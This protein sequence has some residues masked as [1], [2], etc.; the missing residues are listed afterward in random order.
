MNSNEAENN[1]KNGGQP[2]GYQDIL[3]GYPSGKHNRKIL[4]DSFSFARILGARVTIA[5]VTDPFPDQLAFTGP[6]GV[7]PWVVKVIEQEKEQLIKEFRE[8]LMEFE[9]KT[10]ISPT[11]LT[12]E[13][14]PAEVLENLSQDYDITVIGSGR[15]KETPL[16]RLGSVARNVVRFAQS[17]VLVVREWPGEK[18]LGDVKR[19]LVPVDGSEVSGFAVAHASHI[20]QR[21]GA[22]ITLLHVWD[23]KDE[24]VIQRLHT[25]IVRAREVKDILGQKLLDRSEKSLAAGQQAERQIMEGDP[26]EIISGLSGS[27]DLVVMG[28]WGRTGLK[29]FLLGGVA[30]SVANHAHCAVLLIRG[31]SNE[32]PSS[33]T[34]TADHQDRARSFPST[35]PVPELQ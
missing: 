24:K 2:D 31:L 26:A 10:G 12:P 15:E 6:S 7:D 35:R 25:D 8:G 11:V 22:T 28:T 32:S 29:K 4:E 19:I 3:V 34:E 13:G 18:N 27:Y 23:R 33:A 1:K 9:E 17:P 16:R 5:F 20:A 30:E 14:S 21:T